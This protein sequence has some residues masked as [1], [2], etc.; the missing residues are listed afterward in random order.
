VVDAIQ[1]IDIASLPM[2]ATDSNVS[3]AVV[4]TPSG[5]RLVPKGQFTP[6]RGQATS[7]TNGLV[8]WTLPNPIPEASAA[9][10]FG[11][12]EENPVTGCEFT[13]TGKTISGGWITAITGQVWRRNTATLL[14]IVVVQDGLVGVAGKT[15]NITVAPKT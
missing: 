12:V 1:G 14:G 5:A 3:A 2:L 13:P 6:Q 7:G 4:V 8:T 11:Q 9:V 15:V 10:V